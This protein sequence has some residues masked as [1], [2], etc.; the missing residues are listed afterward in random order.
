MSQMGGVVEYV[1]LVTLRTPPLHPFYYLCA[2]NSLICLHEE[3]TYCFFNVT[4][5]L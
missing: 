4:I 5:H 2:L 3:N 1:K